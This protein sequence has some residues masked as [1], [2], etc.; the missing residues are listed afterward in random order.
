MFVQPPLSSPAPPAAAAP[1]G[2]AA[3]LAATSQR[4][5]HLYELGRWIA[6]AGLVLPFNNPL[7]D[8]LLDALPTA[9]LVPYYAQ[10]VLRTRLH[11][12]SGVASMVVTVVALLV[13]GALP[14]A[15]RLVRRRAGSTV[16]SKSETS[17]MR[18]AA[19]ELRR[20]AWWL[21]GVLLR[22]AC[23]WWGLVIAPRSM[24]VAV[25]LWLVASG[26]APGWATRRRRWIWFGAAA[27]FAVVFL[28]A[29]RRWEPSPILLGV[30][31]TAATVML[32]RASSRAWRRRIA[33]SS[34][35]PP[36]STFAAI[37]G[38]ALGYG[39]ASSFFGWSPSPGSLPRV[40][41]AVDVYD[42]S[43]VPGTDRVYFS[44]KTGPPGFV[45]LGN[46]TTRTAVAPLTRSER[47]TFVPSRNRFFVGGD[48]V[49]AFS[50]DDAAYQGNVFPSRAADVQAVDGHLLYI[51]PDSIPSTDPVLFVHDLDSGETRTLPAPFLTSHKIVHDARQAAIFVSTPIG[52]PVLSRYDL[53]NGEIRRKRVGYMSLDMEL[54]DEG[55]KLL[56]ARPMYSRVDVR[57][58]A[59]LSLIR[60]IT[61]DP[62]VREIGCSE[63]DGWLFTLEY[64][65]GNLKVLDLATGRVLFET[66]IGRLARALAYSPE[67]GLLVAGSAFGL[68]EFDLRTL[69]GRSERHA[70]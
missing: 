3:R 10:F 39:F 11:V 51:L 42:V 58:S 32:I 61:I 52:F 50:L 57:D 13:A 68:F 60:S 64:F 8:L 41:D 53:R 31:A 27:V 47:M 20:S 17:A 7:T 5:A 12:S 70:G 14:S 62:M 34:M 49:A 33:W 37:V 65:H 21:V 22:S 54:V 40:G 9:L 36:V 23:I 19:A 18:S 38:L 2:R 1:D 43:F 46:G 24:N 56:V 29:H 6:V 44:S 35:L 69:I 15:T 55:R 30:T 66:R 63:A 67:R 4:L 59:S 48:T 25:G 26:V 16:R 28:A 45:E